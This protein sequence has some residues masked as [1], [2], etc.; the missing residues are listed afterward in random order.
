MSTKLALNL[1]SDAFN[2]FK[3]DFNVML[4]KLLHMMESQEAEEGA[5]NVKMTVKL[6]KGKARDFQSN[7][8]DGT[9]DITTPSFSHKVGISMQFKDEKSGSLIGDYEMSYDKELESYVIADVYNGQLGIFDNEAEPY[10]QDYSVQDNEELL[11]PEHFIVMPSCEII[12][13]TEYDY[14][15]PER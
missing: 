4:R 5:L 13:D 14:D 9:R 2:S 7:G 15:T 8:Y 3:T 11:L 6:E 12:E 10:T 1:E